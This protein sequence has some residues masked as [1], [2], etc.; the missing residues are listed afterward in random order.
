M[1]QL[2]PELLIDLDFIRENTLKLKNLT[3]NHSKFMAILKSDAY[4]HNIK[5]VS[6]ADGCGNHSKD[7]AMQCEA[8]Q[9]WDDKLGVC[10]DTSA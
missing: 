1:K 7:T 3:T 8:G 6:K 10:L 2:S 9:T 4:G 5:K